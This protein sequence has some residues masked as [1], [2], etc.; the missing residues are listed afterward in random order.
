MTKKSIDAHLWI[1][2]INDQYRLGLT[3]AGQEDFGNITFAM[4][5]KVGKALE[6]GDTIVE[7]EAEKAVTEI[8]TSL[9]GIV[10]RVNE[11][12]QNDPSILDSPVEGEAWLVE[13][14]DVDEAAFAQ[15]S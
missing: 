11:A 12:A 13:L 10:S 14:S 4:F 2:K 8:V 15:L 9:K 3:K 6:V 7:F 1:E 5:P